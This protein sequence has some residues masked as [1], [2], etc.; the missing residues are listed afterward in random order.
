M[1]KAVV[2]VLPFWSHLRQRPLVQAALR[3]INAAVVGVLIAAFL[4]PVCSSALH[5]FF[6]SVVAVTALVALLRWKL[7]PWLIVIAVAA[8]SA[9]AAI[10]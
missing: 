6:D 3:G 4:R 1:S 5:S 8:L 7:P 9:L 2:A 10:A